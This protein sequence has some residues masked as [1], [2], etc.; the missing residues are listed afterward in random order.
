MVSL[1]VLVVSLAVTIYLVQKG[2]QLYWGLLAGSVFLSI[3]KGNNL[4]ATAQVFWQ[5]LSSNKAIEL[6]AAVTIITILTSVLTKCN[7]LEGMVKSLSNFLN[8]PKLTIM[9]IPAL[10]GGIPVTGG[11]IISAPL[12]DQLG[13]QLAL[14][15][16]RLAAINV[17]F[18]HVFIFVTPF[19][20]HYIL[21]AS[22]SAI[23]IFTMVKTL[24]P[25]TVL[26]LISGYWVLLRK[27]Q[28]NKQDNL[29]LRCRLAAGFNFLLLASPLSLIFIGI[30]IGLRLDLA[31][32]LGLMLALL[33]AVG[34]PNLN[35]NTIIK[36]INYQLIITIASIA[37]FITV[38]DDLEVLPK[39]LNEI[40]T[41]GISLKLLV[42]VVPLIIGYITADITA[43]IALV[44]PL[45]SPLLP[46]D[47]TRLYYVTTMYAAS[48][49]A[50]I[51]S[52]LH[53]CQVLTIDYFK[54][55]LMQIYR[56]Y[57]S[58]ILILFIGILVL[59]FLNIRVV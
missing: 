23:P 16:A 54:I 35:F 30:I 48:F 50:Y 24:A 6:I 31:L 56:E 10:V 13:S 20:T 33:L 59:F 25:L 18:R 40:I 7:L 47:E 49:I 17:I 39:L 55:N 46:L 43:C 15:N 45:M 57:W 19:R 29:N 21:A 36:G 8:N 11:A 42:F 12:V 27:V 32:S 2:H 14:S 51:I 38:V 26:G 28:A 1:I 41:Y 37:V 3:T 5:G 52:P 44:L 22:L 53:L 34:N 4:K 9:G 58:I